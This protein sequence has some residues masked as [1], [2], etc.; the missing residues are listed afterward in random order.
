MAFFG[1]V[2]FVVDSSYEVNAED[3]SKEKDFVKSL[4]F[5]LNLGPGKSRASVIIYGSEASRAIKFDDHSSLASFNQAVGNL[6]YLGSARRMDLGL[7]EAA[8]AMKAARP[9]NP[10]VVVLLT[11]GRQSLSEGSLDASVKPLKSLG[12]KIFVVAVGSEA[13][14]QE[15]LRVV[16]KTDDVRRVPN[17]DGLALQTRPIAKYIVDNIGKDTN[18]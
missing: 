14:T 13:Y 6:Q 11:A 1:D 16:S 4:A 2:V 7:R 8:A 3:Y 17:F 15:L 12:A 5:T 9:G 10:K 18:S